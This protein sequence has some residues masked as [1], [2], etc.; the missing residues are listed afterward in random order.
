[1]TFNEI[2]NQTD[3]E[4]THALFTDSGIVPK[5]GENNEKLMYQAAHYELVASAEAVK[6]GHEINPDFQIGCMIAMT[7]IYPLTSKP[8]DIL[9]AQRAM[10]TRFWF[11]D[12]HVN[13]FLSTMV[14]E[15]FPRTW[16]RFGYD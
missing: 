6:I 13:G 1:M 4:S 12:V 14:V 11:A 9:F 7:P 5:P 15:S 3:Y 16:F 2:N 10:Q 8:E